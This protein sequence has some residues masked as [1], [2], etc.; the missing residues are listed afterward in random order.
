VSGGSDSLLEFPECIGKAIQGIDNVRLRPGGTRIRVLINP[1]SFR[2]EI[3]LNKYISNRDPA[4]NNPLRCQP[5]GNAGK[6]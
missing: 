6:R 5:Y 2:L 3:M 4:M 1:S